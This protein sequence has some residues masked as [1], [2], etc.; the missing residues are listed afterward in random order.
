M[1]EYELKVTVEYEYTV[2]ADSWEDAERMG[3]KYEDHAYSATVYSIDVTENEP[4]E[5]D[6]EDDDL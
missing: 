2:E 5:E 4:E 3:W 1:A 6:E